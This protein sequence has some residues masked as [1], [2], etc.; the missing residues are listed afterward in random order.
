MQI[1]NTRDAFAILFLLDNTQ[2]A[3]MT[4][5]FESSVS[6]MRSEFKNGKTSES[7]MEKFLEK[8]G[9]QV[10]EGRKWKTPKK[11]K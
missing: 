8:A 3:E 10:V 11:K 9:F 7:T 1:V 4:G 6:R 5:T 2:I